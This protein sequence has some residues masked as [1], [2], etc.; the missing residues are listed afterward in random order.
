MNR[1]LRAGT[2]LSVLL[3]AV[4][5][6]LPATVEARNWTC[7][8]TILLR[9]FMTNNDFMHKPQGTVALTTWHA[10]VGN[11]WRLPKSTDRDGYC[12]DDGK[13]IKTNLY[14]WENTALRAGP[15]SYNPNNGRLT[16][17]SVD[18]GGYP[19]AYWDIKQVNGSVY[20][21]WSR[22]PAPGYR[23]GYLHRRQTWS[24]QRIVLYPHDGV[25]NHWTISCYSN[26][27]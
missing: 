10:G 19:A 4:S 27:R 8:S 11:L 16:P 25:G 9:S 1:E 21:L 13:V 17:G 7:G 6:A 5:L 15:P 22:Q 12:R 24:G 26:C 14:S 3:V 18:A 20:S 2:V 23:G